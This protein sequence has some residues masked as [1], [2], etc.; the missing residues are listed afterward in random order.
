MYSD[1]V[2]RHA[3]C[4]D[5]A[6]SAGHGAAAGEAGDRSCGDRLRVEL[7]IEH[8]VVRRARHRTHA[9]ATATAAVALACKLAE[10]RSLLD[11]ARIGTAELCG[12][13]DAGSNAR[14]CVALA[15]DALHDALACGIESLAEPIAADR[16]AVAMSGGVDSAVA[17]LKVAESGA[18]PVGVTLRLWID[19]RPPTVSARAA[20]RA[21]CA[22]PGTPVTR[23]VCRTSRSTCVSASGPSVVESFLRD[24]RAGLTPNPCVRCNGSFR[25]DALLA[26]ADRIGAARLA[27]GHYAR[28]ERRGG[29]PLVARGLDSAKDQS[30]M[31]ARIDPALLDRV[32]FPLGE[33]HKTETRDQARSAGMAAAGRRESQEVCFVGGGDHRDFVQR[34]GGGG[35][36]GEIVHADGRR[37]GRHG[38]VHRFTPGQRRGLGVGGPGEPLYVLATD[39]ASGRVVA[40]PRRLLARQIVHV[41]PGELYTGIERVEAKLRYRSAAV[42][43][44]VR[45]VEDGFELE[46]DEAAHGVAPGQVAVLY[47][48]DAVVGA[49][50]ISA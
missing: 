42:G 28:V 18:H 5:R 6:G 16:V 46:L 34:H 50:V 2:I 15:V 41:R 3:L 30:Y 25:F 20:R 32:W 27:T 22:L 37:L 19:R 9:C 7:A 8:G 23:W 33:Q 17:L 38:G 47:D 21:R 43:A 24:H 39:P 14:E 12:V 49:G 40:G 31:L 11:A 4:T 48:G 35:R 29:R 1:A 36:P 45:P 26:V 44:S 10:G 13:L